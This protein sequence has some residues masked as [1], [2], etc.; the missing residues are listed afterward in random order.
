MTAAARTPPFLVLSSQRSFEAFTGPVPASLRERYVFLKPGQG[1]RILATLPDARLVVSQSYSRPEVNRFIFDARRQ[2]VPTMLLVDGPLEWSNLYANPSLRRPGAGSPRGLFQPI[3]HDAVATIG[4]AQTRFIESRN[5]GRGIAFM[6]YANHRIQTSLAPAAQPEFDF[7]LTTAR[8]PAFGEHE[9]RDLI[10]A[11]VACAEALSAAGHR[12]LVRIFDE[13]I[14]RAVQ[15]AAP[16]AEMDGSDEFVAALT[17]C[18][19]VIGTPSSVLLE[20]MHHDRPTATLVYRDSPLLYP[21][22]WLL[23]GFTDWRASFRSMLDRDPDRM[24]L[25]QQS[26]RENLSDRDFFEQTEAIARG[27]WLTAPRPLDE[28]DLAF[29]N[30]VLRQLVGWRARLLAPLYREYREWRAYFDS[31]HTR[32]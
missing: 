6:S 30:Q 28:R 24:A 12:T 3:V 16:D 2:G 18:R 1:A 29:E 32:P 17:R 23:G 15:R 8:T 19:C 4:R 13:E 14:R 26:L 27:E 11:L 25:Q 21:T 22:G 10:R 7:L 9:R 31:S 5:G 20:A